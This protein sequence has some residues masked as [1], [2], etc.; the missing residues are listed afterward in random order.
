MR[1]RCTVGSTTVTILA[2]EVLLR[3][4]QTGSAYELDSAL[5]TGPKE[6]GSGMKGNMQHT[7]G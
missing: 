5:H 1:N 4:S 6:V 3:V 7:K 2:L